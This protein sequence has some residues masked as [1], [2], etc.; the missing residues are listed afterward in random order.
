MEKDLKA[1]SE[2]SSSKDDLQRLRAEVKKIYDGLHIGA[3]R[4]SCYYALRPL[5]KILMNRVPRP[6]VLRMG[7]T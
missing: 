6:E 4:N 7:Y 5:L 3:Y 2:S 1:L